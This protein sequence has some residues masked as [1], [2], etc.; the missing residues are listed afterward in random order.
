MPVVSTGEF[1]AYGSLA[2][3]NTLYL[4]RDGVLNSAVIRG[5]GEVSSP[6]SVGEFALCGDVSALAD[7]FYRADWNLVVVTN[8]PDVSRGLIDD[9]LL[10]QFHRSISAVIPLGAA[11]F[12]PHQESENCGCRKP[13]PGMIDGFRLAFPA[14]LRREAMIG[15]R[16]SD[17]LCA[18]AAGVPFFLRERPYNSDL[19]PLSDGVVTDL[20]ELKHHLH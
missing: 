13:A 5:R 6:R 20:F 7:E 19:V 17:L 16:E 18:R 3:H 1:R 15:D 14:A 8:Q 9:E 12:C 4:D 2:G 10:F 11:L